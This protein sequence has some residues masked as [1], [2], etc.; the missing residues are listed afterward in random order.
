VKNGVSTTL[1]DLI[2]AALT[3]QPYSQRRLGDESKRYALG[4]VRRKAFELPEDVREDVAQEAFVALF[5]A[6]AAALERHGGGRRLFHA[7]VLVAIRR[8]RA[9]YIEPGRR[10]RLPVAPRNAADRDALAAEASRVPRDLTSGAGRSPDLA[11]DE[12]LQR[13]EDVLDAERIMASA[14]DHMVRILR[15]LHWDDQK[16]AVVASECSISRFTLRRRLIAFSEP[17]QA[18]A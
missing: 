15:S 3:G 6:G 13:I 5:E 10:T 4:L 14:P 12:D 11:S 16:L 7:C 1:D 2:E 8:V 18:A 17:W 9:R